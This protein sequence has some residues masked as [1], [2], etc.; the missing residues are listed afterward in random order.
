MAE[1][2]VIIKSDLPEGYHQ[3]L[4]NTVKKRHVKDF[5]R[6]LIVMVLDDKIEIPN[7]L[8]KYLK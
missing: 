6:S 2:R 1:K 5:T 8:K 7:Q 4:K 3:K